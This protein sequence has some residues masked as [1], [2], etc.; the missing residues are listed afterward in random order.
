MTTIAEARAERMGII[1]D[2]VFKLYLIFITTYLLGK[3]QGW[4]P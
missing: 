4:I 2:L 1:A 3:I